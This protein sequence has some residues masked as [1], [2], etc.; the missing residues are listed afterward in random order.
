MHAYLTL[1][2]WGRL[3][4]CK[5]PHVAYW[6][7]TVFTRSMCDAPACLLV[8]LFVCTFENMRAKACLADTQW[9]R[10][11]G[12]SILLPRA[13]VPQTITNRILKC[14]AAEHGRPSAWPQDY[15]FNARNSHLCCPAV[16]GQSRRQ[17]VTGTSASILASGMEHVKVPSIVTKADAWLWEMHP[18]R[19]PLPLFKTF[20]QFMQ[21]TCCLY[22]FNAAFQQLQCYQHIDNRWTRAIEENSLSP[23][24]SDTHNGYGISP[25]CWCPSSAI[26]IVSKLP[27]FPDS[28]GYRTDAVPGDNLGNQECTICFSHNKGPTETLSI[29]MSKRHVHAHAHSV[30]RR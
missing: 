15:E 11:V 8:Y 13:L 24:L 19:H 23:G 4:F 14:C 2:L 27:C 22:T 7:C 1:L 26:K 18:I 12:L 5:G 16:L 30:F 9:W 21:S 10:W 20:T 28:Q 17:A 3:Y 29:R 6:P 25:F